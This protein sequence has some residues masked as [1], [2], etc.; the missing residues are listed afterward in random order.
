MRQ[1]ADVLPKS[2]KDIEQ[3]KAAIEKLTKLLEEQPDYSDG[4]MMRVI[5]N[6]CSLKSADSQAILKDIN[7]S[8][9][10][11]AAQK[12][13]GAFP[14]LANHYSLRAKV[15]FDIKRFPEAMDDLEAAMRQ[16]LRTAA[17]IFNSGGT[18]PEATSPDSCVWSLSDL[19]TLVQRF[20]KD[21]RAVLFR[22]LYMKSFDLFDEKSNEVAF[23]EFEKA[24]VLDP[25]SPL[26]HFY[27]GAVTGSLFST[28]VR[29]GSEEVRKELRTKAVKFYRR[30]IVLDPGLVPAY[31][32]RADMYLHLAQYQD[33]VRDYDKVLELNPEN[34]TAYTGRGEAKLALGQY[35]EAIGDYNAVFRSGTDDDKRYLY[36]ERADAYIKVGDELNAISDLSK[37]IE[38]QLGSQGL[39]FSL[40]Q[41]R[42]LYPEYRSVSDEKLCRKLNRLFWPQ[43]EYTV[44]AKHIAENTGQWSISGFNELYEQRG[45]AYLKSGSFRKGVNDFN[46]I[47]NA[48]PFG[49]LRWSDGGRCSSQIRAPNSILI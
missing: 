11:H 26:P 1:F 2:D 17:A 8:I 36:E 3:V 34:M 32:G 9:S 10:T 6:R 13:P 43:I 27:M 24:A 22:G 21:Y 47:W 20:P 49:R 45:D 39:S 44:F 40:G 46:R 4:Y 38:L 30:A 12:S 15:K 29:R 14:S 33:A 37:A 19:D 7:T 31:E 28:K 48:F 16:N 35:R 18:R 5:F 23:R 25:Q 42:A 41:F